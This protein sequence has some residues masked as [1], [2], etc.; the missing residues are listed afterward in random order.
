LTA[1]GAEFVT[2]EAKELR[3]TIETRQIIATTGSIKIDL[4]LIFVSPGRRA[5]T[6]LCLVAKT[7]VM[8]V[9]NPSC[10]NIAGVNKPGL[11]ID[12]SGVL[13]V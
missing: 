12:L 10:T 3:R 7:T 2:G 11:S 1:I 13:N 9:I 8:S 5:D 6:S 4:I